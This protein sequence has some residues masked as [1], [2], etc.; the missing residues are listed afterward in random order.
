M[1]VRASVTRIGGLFPSPYAHAYPD[2]QSAIWKFKDP[3]WG[4][5]GGHSDLFMHFF[6]SLQ[7]LPFLLLYECVGEVL[8]TSPPA[9]STFHN[10]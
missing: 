6:F 4:G 1:R 2:I 5:G 8:L 3:K 9:F 7:N 10:S